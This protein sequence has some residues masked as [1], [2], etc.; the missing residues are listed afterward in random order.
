MRSSVPE[1]YAT[2]DVKQGDKTFLPDAERA[3]IW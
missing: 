2:F 1:Y 3:K